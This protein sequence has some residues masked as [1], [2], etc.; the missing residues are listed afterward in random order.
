MDGIG[1]ASKENCMRGSLLLTTFVIVGLS[2][3]WAEDPEIKLLPDGVMYG[4]I[5][6]CHLEDIDIENQRL[7]PAFGTH[8]VVDNFDLEMP[9]EKELCQRQK[10]KVDESGNIYLIKN[11][12]PRGCKTKDLD[13]EKFKKI[14]S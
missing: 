5:K 14:F 2:V 8:W 6:V 3:A 7:D 4:N 1:I 13:E 9:A 11:A 10:Y 12:F